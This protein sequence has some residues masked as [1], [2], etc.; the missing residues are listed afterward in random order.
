MT[1]TMPLSVYVMS[2]GVFVISTSEF[3]IM[4]LLPNLAR[5]LHVPL[6]TAGY[7]V[8]GYAIG[9]VLGAPLL[10]P[11]LVTLPR[12]TALT[13]LMA[14][15]ALGNT[16]CALAPGY[17]VLLAA[18]VVSALAQASFLGLGAVVARGLVPPAQQARAVSTVFLGSTV[19][20]M[21]GAPAGTAFGQHFGW[22]ATFW[23]LAALAALALVAVA[24]RLPPLAAGAAADL[25]RECATLIRP[26][27][28]RALLVTT[29]GFGGT[30]TT[31]TFIAPMLTEVSGLSEAWV[32]PILLLFGVGMFLGNPIGGR[33]ADRSLRAAVP[34]TLTALILVLALTALV[35]PWA[36]PMVAAVFLFG[37]ALFATVAPL[38][39][40][41]MA[42]AADAPVLSSAFNIAAF[43]LGNAAGAYA[44][45]LA[46][47]QGLALRSLPWVGVAISL[48]GLALALLPRSTRGLET[49]EA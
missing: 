40:Q 43:N 5:D 29:L 21:A 45:S 25:R 27:M 15:F 7:L 11:F 24:R 31:F 32:S 16:V 28:L 4:G 9:V 17:D 1:A 39:M 14:L 36:L 26:P 19:A 46:L 48:C 8:S 30:F 2:L 38:Q 13:A 18:R 34:I 3:V 12:K 37:V 42:Q 35:M 10:T 49:G 23:V 33:L 22:R 44:G 20:T 6:A 41:V 47:E